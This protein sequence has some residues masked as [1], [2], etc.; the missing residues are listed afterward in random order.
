[1]HEMNIAHFVHVKQFFSIG[2]VT[3]IVKIALF[4]H[5]QCN[6]LCGCIDTFSKS[7]EVRIGFPGV[8]RYTVYSFLTMLSAC[9]F[10]VV[11]EC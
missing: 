9:S 5:M 1:M 6:Q 3:S 4:T 8:Y 7:L 10:G 11:I 2:L